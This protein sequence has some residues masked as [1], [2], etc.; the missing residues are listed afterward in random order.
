MPPPR[1][2]S[3]APPQEFFRGVSGDGKLSGENFPK[4]DNRECI[5]AEIK[6]RWHSCLKHVHNYGGVQACKWIQIWLFTWQ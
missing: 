1:G 6:T 2:V 4:G 3:V 5:F